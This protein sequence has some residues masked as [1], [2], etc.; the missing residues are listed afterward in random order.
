M[1]FGSTSMVSTEVVLRTRPNEAAS[2]WASASI[3]PSNVGTATSAGP[4]ETT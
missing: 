4:V 1:V 3:M 2:V